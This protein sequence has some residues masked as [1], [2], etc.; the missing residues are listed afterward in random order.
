MPEDQLEFARTAAGFWHS[1]LS[2][3]HGALLAAAIGNQGEM[4]APRIVERAFGSEGQ[5]LSVPAG[6]AR[7]VM[8]PA[9]AR[10]GTSS[11]RPCPAQPAAW[12]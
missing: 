8:N 9:A 5:P 11:D 4:P 12:R 2:P 3:L 6:R 10:D 1:T 7:T